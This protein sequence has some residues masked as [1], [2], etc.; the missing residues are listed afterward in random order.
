VRLLSL[1]RAGARRS[2]ESLLRPGERAEETARRGA[3]TMRARS[4]RSRDGPSANPAARSR[5]QRAGARWPGRSRVPF[6][7]VTSLWA[8]K[9][10]W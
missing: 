7:L 10:K 5:S 2:S 1:L 3:R 4:L 6:L 9:E 8:S